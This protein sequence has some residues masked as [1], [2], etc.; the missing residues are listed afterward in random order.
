MSDYLSGELRMIKID[1]AYIFQ[2]GSRMRPILDIPEVERSKFDMYLSTDDARTALLEFM[3]Q[4]VFREEL[5]PVQKS[6]SLLSDELDLYNSN[7][8]MRI[9]EDKM[10][11][12]PWSVRNLKEKYRE[13]EHVLNATLQMSSMYYVSPKGGYN[14]QYLTDMGELIFPKELGVKV[15]NAV[16]DIKQAARCIAFE[17]PTAAGFHLH[18]ANESVL[19]VY[20]DNVTDGKERPEE[21]NMGIYLGEL[22]KLNK[23]KKSVREH[24]KSIKDFHRNPLMHPEQSLETVEEAIGLLAAI[25]CSIGYMLTEIGEVKAPLVLVSELET[26]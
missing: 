1:G 20:W 24:L 19:R 21:G 17:L 10:V 11:V 4:S 15:P 6:A 2:F 18:R 14:T 25:R 8:P 3:L 9:F 22:N 12:Y 13:F 23:G 16:A 26:A 7:E 5:G